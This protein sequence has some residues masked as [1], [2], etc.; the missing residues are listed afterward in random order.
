MLENII[1]TDANAKDRDLTK[2]YQD[3]G[4][5]LTTNQGLPVA[6]DNNSL[7]AGIRGPSLIEDLY[8]RE[9]INHFDH[10]RIPERV[11]HAR[12]AAAHGY[13]ECTHPM[14]ESHRA[15]LFARPRGRKTPV[16]VRFST[17]AGSRGSPDTP[18]DVRGFGQVLH[19]RGRVGHGRQQHP[20]VLHPGRDQV[21]R[22][23]PRREARAGQRDP[24][25]PERARHVL[26]LRQPDAGDHPHADVGDERPGAAA[27]VLATWRGLASTRSG[28]STRRARA[29]FVKF[30]FKPK[31][32][33]RRWCGT[34][35]TS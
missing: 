16:F 13:F 15:G 5:Q 29:T 22:P 25:G 20:G 31:A 26:R 21:P 27:D 17:V 4:Q 33:L 18:R 34:R 9:K 11:V 12:G 8:L 24:A 35:A 14:G 3:A 10:E 30:H 32:G 1:P 28:G 2:D 19:R 6:D 23:D 7:R